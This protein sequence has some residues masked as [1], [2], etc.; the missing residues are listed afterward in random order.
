MICIKARKDRNRYNKQNVVSIYYC[1]FFKQ[2][3]YI[4][5]SIILVIL[6]VW[7]KVKIGCVMWTYRWIS[8]KILW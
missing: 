3:V 1:N 8:E 2:L 7:I 4:S 6:Y 5:I